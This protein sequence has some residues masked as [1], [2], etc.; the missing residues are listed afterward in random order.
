[1]V[2]F[3]IWAMTVEHPQKNSFLC[4]SLTEDNLGYKLR[5]FY[6][7]VKMFPLY[8][9]VVMLNWMQQHYLLPHLAWPVQFPP[10]LLC[11]ETQHRMTSPRRT[12]DRASRQ[13][14]TTFLAFLKATVLEPAW[15]SEYIV[16]STSFIPYFRTFHCF[17]FRQQFYL[18]DVSFIFKSILLLMFNLST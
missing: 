2:I 8:Y 14:I 17:H 16:N 10:T 5:L 18:W 7:L 12:H 13:S 6:L 9:S 1:M 11:T 4:S 15:L 3:C